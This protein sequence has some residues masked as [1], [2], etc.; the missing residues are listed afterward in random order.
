MMNLPR[1]VGSLRMPHFRGRWAIARSL[2]VVSLAILLLSWSTGPA[3]AVVLNVYILTGQ[4]NALGTTFDE[5]ATAAQY[6]PGTDPADGNTQFFWANVNASNTVHPPVLYGDSTGAVTTLMMQQGYNHPAEFDP[7]FWGP[8]FGFARI[9]AAAGQS[10][11]L[12]IKASRGGGGNTLWDKATFDSNPNAGHMWGALRDSVGVALTAAQNAGYQLQVRGLLYEQ[13]ESNNAAESSIADVRL[14]DL[15]ANLKQYVNTNFA[16]AARNMQ[17]V[18]AEASNSSWS[19]AASTTTTRQRSLADSRSDVAFIQTHDQLLKSDNLH[20]GRDAKLTIGQRFADAFLD[21]Q[22]R[23]A[24]VLARYTADLAS[25]SL[26]PHPS[27]QSWTETGTAA[28][29]VTPNVVLTGV[30]ENGTRGWQINDD[31]STCNP[32]Y[33]QPLTNNDYQAMFD[34]GWNLRAKV[35]VIDGEG[36]AFWSVTAPNAPAEWGVA[37]G[38]GNIIGFLVDRVGGDQ[39]QVKLLENQNAQTINLGAGSAN[40]FHTLELVGQSGSGAFDFLVD[41]QFRFA[42]AIPIAV[43]VAGFEDRAM[44]NSASTGGVGRNVIW[45]EVSL[46]VG[47]PEPSAMVMV[48]TGLLALAGYLWRKRN[49]RYPVPQPGINTLRKD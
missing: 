45:N 35:K 40:E 4:S 12:I 30:T 43:G 9:L 39:F 41:G 10:N 34:K 17:T 18:A 26:V 28:S 49:A 24:S 46:A 36:A 3:R 23:P 11:V 7:A 21:L 8:E 29:G 2:R 14:S 20:F 13:G 5:G 42:S 33:Y 38:A 19:P 16:N 15:A 27:T 47:V 37:G 1:T 32:G 22:S 6:G 25:P 44:F 31:S 48:D